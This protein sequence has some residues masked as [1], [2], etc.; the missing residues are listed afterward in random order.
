MANK[1]SGKTHTSKG[2]RRSSMKTPTT[3]SAEKMLNKQAAWVKGS[4]PWVTIENPIKMKRTS[5]LSVSGIMIYSTGRT[6]KLRKK[7]T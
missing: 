2:E 3:N 4:N 5:H 6:V 1:S 7:H